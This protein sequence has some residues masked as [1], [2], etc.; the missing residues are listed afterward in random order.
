MAK[1][2]LKL[3]VEPTFGISTKAKQSYEVIEYVN[4]DLF[5]KLT[6]FDNDGNKIFYKNIISNVIILEILD[7]LSKT[8]IKV[9]PQEQFICDG[10][11]INLEIDDMRGKISLS[12]ISKPPDGWEQLESVTEKII[13]LIPNKAQ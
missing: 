10:D 5:I 8:T 2:L 11:F 1:R 12:W 13:N 6:G 4:G 7:L 3:T 9:L